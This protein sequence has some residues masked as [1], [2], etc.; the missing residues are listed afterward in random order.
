MCREENNERETGS[1]GIGGHDDRGVLSIDE[2]AT[3]VGDG[4]QDAESDE[5]E[6]AGSNGGVPVVGDGGRG[7][8]RDREEQETK[9]GGDVDAGRENSQESGFPKRADVGMGAGAGR[10][11]IEEGDDSFENAGGG[12]A[13][14]DASTRSSAEPKTSGATDP[15]PSFQGLPMPQSS[16][17]LPLLD[18]PEVPPFVPPREEPAERTYTFHA[19]P[20]AETV[21]ISRRGEP[22][23][24]VPNLREDP[25]FTW[26]ADGIG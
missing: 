15:E 17:D 14:E 20:P 23:D 6:S 19:F 5:E 12:D 2:E 26:E 8:W 11:D 7:Q 18:S 9:H 25:N 24:S 3:G 22:V 10:V 13:A 16:N 4:L 1:A 21:T